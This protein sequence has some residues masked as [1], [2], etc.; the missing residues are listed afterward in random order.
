MIEYTPARDHGWHASINGNGVSGFHD[1]GDA[2]RYTMPR[3]CYA[4][5][6]GGGRLCGVYGDLGDRS[7]DGQGE[8]R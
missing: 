7:G 8:G 4:Y 1:C 5:P 2:S 3:Q 6:E